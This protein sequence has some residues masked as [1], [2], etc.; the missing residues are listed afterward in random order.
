ML[1]FKALAIKEEKKR[2]NRIKK[3]Y[4][5]FRKCSFKFVEKSNGSIEGWIIPPGKEKSFEAKIRNRKQGLSDIV[6]ITDNKLPR[7]QGRS[8]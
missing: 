8:K 1:S 2:M 4:E 7:M 6:S 3:Q 5:K